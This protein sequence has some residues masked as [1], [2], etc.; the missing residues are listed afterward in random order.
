LRGR[1]ILFCVDAIQ[2]VGAFPTF[3]EYIDFLAADA[4]KWMLGPCA[5]GIFYVRK[6]LHDVLKPMVLGTCLG[7]SD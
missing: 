2:T 5:A 3:V 1:D 6:E 4:H 7:W